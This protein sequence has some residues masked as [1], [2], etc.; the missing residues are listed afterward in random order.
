[1]H[2]NSVEYHCFRYDSHNA[3]QYKTNKKTT[4]GR[5]T[6][7]MISRIYLL[8]FP[9]LYKHIFKNVNYIVGCF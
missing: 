3:K 2:I 8:S 6:R 7:K 9:F 4:M 1:M 5:N